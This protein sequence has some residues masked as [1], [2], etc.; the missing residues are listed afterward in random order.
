MLD[1]EDRPGGWDRDVIDAQEPV[2]L[3]RRCHCGQ[4]QPEPVDRFEDGSATPLG[5]GPLTA[6][7]GVVPV[8]AP[9]R[10]GNRCNAC[11]GRLGLRRSGR[12]I[13]V[14]IGQRTERPVRSHGRPAT[15]RS[16][17]WD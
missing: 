3:V 12:S 5:A 8:P 17:G 13:P 6:S 15:R 11:D 7:H 10:R 14:R 16:A 4:L 9:H 2:D 1:V